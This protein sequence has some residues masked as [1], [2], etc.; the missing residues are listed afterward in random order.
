M[1]ESAKPTY[2]SQ[3]LTTPSTAAVPVRVRNVVA[4][5][6]LGNMLGDPRHVIQRPISKVL[7]GVQIDIAG[8]RQTPRLGT[9]DGVRR[10]TQVRMSSIGVGCCIA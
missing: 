5:V 8:T 1:S 9:E 7:Q 4:V 10:V 2:Q 3:S 6:S